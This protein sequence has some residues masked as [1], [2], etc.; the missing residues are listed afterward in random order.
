MKIVAKREQEQ[1]KLEKEIMITDPNFITTKEGRAWVISQQKTI[2]ARVTQ[3]GIGD[4]SSCS[5]V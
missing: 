2:W 5:E 4:G 3:Q 1:L